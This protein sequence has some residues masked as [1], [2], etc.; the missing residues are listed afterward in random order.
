MCTVHHSL[1]HC[2]EN[3][4]FGSEY[5]KYVLPGVSSGER[6]IEKH[7][8]IVNEEATILLRNGVCIKKSRVL[9][10]RDG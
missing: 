5:N 6:K 1:G 3:S 10:G 7:K 4:G 2:P 9:Y 8:Y